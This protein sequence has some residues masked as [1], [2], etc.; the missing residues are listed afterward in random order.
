MGDGEEGERGG[1]GEGVD[2][3]LECHVCVHAVLWCWV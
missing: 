1:E 3:G 2:E